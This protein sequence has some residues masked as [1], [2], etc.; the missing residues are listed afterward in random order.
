MCLLLRAPFA[1]IEA[2]P[3]YQ[4]AI[5]IDIESIRGCYMADIFPDKPNDPSVDGVLSLSRSL[6]DVT[7]NR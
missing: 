6:Q 3:A 5:M 4:R 2:N 1:I 7:V